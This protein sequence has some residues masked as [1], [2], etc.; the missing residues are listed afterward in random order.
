MV[1]GVELGTCSIRFS[2]CGNSKV[3]NPF[4]LQHLAKA[5]PQNPGCQEHGPGRCWRPSGRHGGRARR[6]PRAVDAEKCDLGGDA[7]R[8]GRLGGIGG[9]SI[10]STFGTPMEMLQQVA[11]I[12]GDLHD[13]DPDRGNAR[14]SHGVSRAC[15]TQLAEYDEK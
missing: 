9:G 8:N 12:R 2:R 3:S 5:S 1:D 7:P 6:L 4:R 15:S 13:E 11:V 10:P 14:A